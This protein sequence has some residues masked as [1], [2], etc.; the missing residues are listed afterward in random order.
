MHRCFLLNLRVLKIKFSFD[1]KQTLFVTASKHHSPAA[2]A[3]QGYGVY[4]RN[5]MPKCRK[6]AYRKMTNKTILL[7]LIFFTSQTIYSQNLMSKKEIYLSWTKH[8][9]DRENPDNYKIGFES[10]V[11]T[12]ID[13]LKVFGVDTIGAYEQDYVGSEVL[14]SCLCGIIPWEAYVHWI[15]NGKIYH[16]RFTKCCINETKQIE[17]SVLINYYSATKTKIDNERIMPVITGTSKGKNGETLIDFLIVDHTTDFTL[18]CTLSGHSRF[19]RFQ[20]YDL[21]NKDGIFQKDNENSTINSWRKMIENQIEE[22]E[23]Q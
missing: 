4:L 21:E 1:E 20:Y 15:K 17:Y 5:V 9:N 22:I 7:F 11:S 23:K 6:K 3:T 12:F 16:R 18:F 19:T 14:D 8:D 10:I 2:G 13:S